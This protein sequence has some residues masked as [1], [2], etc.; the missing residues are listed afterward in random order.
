MTASILRALLGLCLALPLCG[1]GAAPD[2]DQFRLCRIAL[3]ALA[4]R[5]AVLTV[6]KQSAVDAKSEVT[7]IQIAA[8]STMPDGRSD[9]VFAECR[10]GRAA[11]GL[12]ALQGI[13]TGA[14]T[15][16][17]VSLQLLTRFWLAS[18]DSDG[19]DP[20]PVALLPGAPMLRLPLA[21]AL[22]NGLGAL[23]GMAIYG[24][25]ATAYSLV[26]G[27]AGRI[28]LA[29]GAMA[30]I[31]GAASLTGLGFLADP[32]LVMM[33]LAAVLAALW[34]GTLHG[35]ALARW[36]FLPLGRVS[37]QHGLVATVGLALV[38][39]EYI[40][41]AQGATPLWIAPLRAAPIGVAQAD[42]FIVTVTP[43]ALA[44]TAIF[45]ASAA[46]VL[47][48]MA[49][50][51]FGRNWRA[52]ADDPKAAALMG[53]DPVR[54][55]GTTF[56]LASA[57]AGASGAMTVLIYGSFGASFGTVLGLKA[58]LAAVL[59]G[60]GSVPG[61]F[62]GG[63][64]IALLEAAWSAVFPIEYRDLALFTILVAALVTRPGGFLGYRDLGPRRV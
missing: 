63:V 29:F 14:G 38:L 51:Q 54:M 33:I 35:V 39:G 27:L 25:L 6:V 28:N 4:E 7:V 37:G 31:G 19:A 55:F 57:L 46:A 47:I 61:A 36:V 49:R 11:A 18:P 8:R 56:A 12:D 3:V 21:Q 60:I 45:A 59:G 40:R 44:V 20:Q 42:R 62:L 17:P 43:L 34:A 53:V 41:L 64:T 52:M 48:L 10:F 15:L 50:S 30:A 22:Q 2:A 24:L 26:Y 13:R 58:L 5:D 1:C 16:S 9:P 23:P 32:P